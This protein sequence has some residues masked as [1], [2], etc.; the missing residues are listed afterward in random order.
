[1]FIFRFYYLFKQF[2]S[3]DKV[4]IEDLIRVGKQYVTPLF[5][6]AAKIAIV[7]HPDKA[8][9]VSAYFNQMGHRLSIGSS[10]DE[11]IL[12]SC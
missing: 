4:T 5:T 12:G 9:D 11:S 3:I 2:Q 10:L 1:M 7:C 8:G 6:S